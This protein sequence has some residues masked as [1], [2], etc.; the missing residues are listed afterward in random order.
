MELWNKIVYDSRIYL[1]AW[2]KHY[3]KVSEIL[4]VYAP[5]VRNL[6]IMYPGYKFEIA[7][8]A[9]GAMGCVPKCLVTYLK[10]VGF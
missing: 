3:K 7:P 6:Q 1:P 4:E 10:V 8:I 5:L 2:H 9:V